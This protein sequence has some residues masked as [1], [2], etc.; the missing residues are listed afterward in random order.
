MVI[1]RAVADFTS[2]TDESKKAKLTLKEL[3]DTERS[4]NDASVR[5]SADNAIAR[6]RAIQKIRDE[7]AA[8][9]A[10]ATAQRSLNDAQRS[11]G[12]GLL[13]AVDLDRER[14]AQ[15]LLNRSRQRGFFTPQQDYAFRQTEITQQQQY[16]RA[17]W[18]GAS[19]E[20]QHLQGMAQERAAWD[21]R[22]RV[23]S[24]SHLRDLVSR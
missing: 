14:Q 10:E 21:Q 13:S 22:D 1:F 4:M 9:L 24:G 7:T 12:A 15:D 11:G 17:A 23:A 19:S 18:G 16:W 2:L 6:D 20:A 8:I 3:Q 5:G